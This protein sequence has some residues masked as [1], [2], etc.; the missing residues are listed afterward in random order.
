MV[1]Q[2]ANFGEYKTFG[3]HVDTSADGSGKPVSLVDNT[4]RT[5]IATEMKRKGYEEAATGSAADL[6]IDYE[7]ARTETLKNK[8]FRVGIG[9]GSYGSGVG[10]SVSTS[11]SSV[12]NV[13]EGSLVIHA[14]D[15]A[16]NAEVWRSRVSRELGKDT[17][18]PE[19]IQSAVA[20]VFSDF[21]ARTASTPD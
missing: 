12:K 19:V 5:A 14:I 1:D 6:L 10:G 20:E 13:S 17:V 7:A 4:I 3:W 8:P 11:S 9:V 16:R 18:K 21:P 2:Q 15:S